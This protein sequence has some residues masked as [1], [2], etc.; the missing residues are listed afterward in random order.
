MPKP[1]ER[2]IE[3]TQT[4]LARWLGTRIPGA[5]A[6]EIRSL[7][8]PEATG[9]SS[10]TL[11]FDFSWR[12]HGENRS[13]PVVVRLEPS[14]FQVFPSYEIAW[15]YRLMDA[16]GRVGVPTPRMLWLEENPSALGARFYVMERIDGQVPPDRPPYH[17]HGWLLDAPPS[18]RAAIWRSGIDAMARIH[19]ADWRALGF[20]FLDRPEHGETGIDQQL[21]YYERYLEWALAGDRHPACEQALRWLR[22]NQPTGETLRLCW[23]DA[24]IGNMI[25]R[26]GRCAAV[27]DWEMATLGNPVQDLA[28]Y[29]Y[30]DRH[31]CE[32]IGVPRLEGFPSRD[33]TIAQWER[34]TGLSARKSID[35]Y[36]IF[37]G[38][39][40][41][42]IM[43]R[44]SRQMKH[45]EQ[46]SADSDF[47][48][49]NPASQLLAKLLDHGITP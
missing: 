38:L 24:R 44:V 43:I 11:L 42:A 31:H 23:G 27:L 5:D 49:N 10:D 28:W 47:D 3:K 36:E 18:E 37:A 26:D 16:L 4:D 2:S 12:E 15:Q 9:F 14:G 29:L 34:A 32:G 22:A 35:Y 33:E 17:M 6:I 7:G 19:T 20:Q 48:L 21:G 40:F 13:A 46:L 25:F 39:R 41:A 30:L 1:A 8:G 45:Y